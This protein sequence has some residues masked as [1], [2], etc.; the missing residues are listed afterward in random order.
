MTSR[1]TRAFFQTKSVEPTILDSIDELNPNKILGL[2]ENLSEN[3]LK[4]SG[5]ILK[6]D[7]FSESLLETKRDL[8]FNISSVND[9]KAGTALKKQL[10]DALDSIKK[11]VA[12][13]TGASEFKS[14]L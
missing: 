9:L 7:E 4:N 13:M 10:G 3:T 11:L 5:A 14:W 2:P 12:T 8:H 6:C 1:T